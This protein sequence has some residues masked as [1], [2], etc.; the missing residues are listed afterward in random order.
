MAA[1]VTHLSDL[2]T[3]ASE[4]AERL[5]PSVVE[6]ANGHGHGAG[7]IWR[8][9]GLI[10]TNHHVVP[11]DGAR[12]RLADGRTLD[13][14]TVA[15]DPANDLALLKVEAQGLPAAA[16]GDARRLRAGEIVL[17]IGHPYGNRGSLTIGIVVAPLADR[18][19]E[20]TRELVRAA[21]LLGPGNSGGPLADARGRVVGINSMVAGGLA[22][23]VP[24]HLVER[25]LRWQSGADRPWIGIEAK[26]V[27][28]P[29]ALASAAGLARGVLVIG[30]R[31]D[32]P[33]ERAGVLLGD[34]LVSA[35]ERPVGSVD[36]LIEALAAH[37]SGPARLGLVRGGTASELWIAPEMVRQRAA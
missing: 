23:A 13:A 8:A 14:A 33:A 1:V 15:R 37:G 21:V 3:A 12:V 31:P 17:A 10:A 32:S 25:L 7:T 29:P 9:D 27:E 18:Y 4:V 24:S 22:L 2:G 30:V 34:V 19:P 35:A 26:E 6:I 20:Q 11:G 5:R 28:L 16:G 36:D